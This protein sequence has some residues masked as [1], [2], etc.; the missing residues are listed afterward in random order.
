M[1]IID[2]Y[3]QAI[4]DVVDGRA[5]LPPR[6]SELPNTE[7]KLASQYMA[8]AAL[9]KVQEADDGPNIVVAEVYTEGSG[10]GAH[11]ACSMTF[12]EILD[13][14]DAGKTVLCASRDGKSSA[15]VIHKK[16]FGSSW[17]LEWTIFSFR[18]ETFWANDYS[19]ISGAAYP[20]GSS[21]SI[22]M[23]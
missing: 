4:Q 23:E 7:D 20:S 12:Q 3:K 11:D 21:Y 2:E 8:A 10:G 13:A 18:N 1:A 17:S 6:P 9:A 15:S 16:A 22:S 5:P 14:I 19:W